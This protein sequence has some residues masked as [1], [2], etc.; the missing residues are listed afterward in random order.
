MI[1][2]AIFDLYTNVIQSIEKQEKSS[3]I[4][5]DFVK[6]FDTEDHRILLKDLDY[7][8]VRGIALRF[9]ESY[10]ANSKQAVKIGLYHSS[11]QAVVCVVPQESVLGPLLFLIYINDIHISSLKVKFHLF[12]DDTCIFNSGKNLHTLENEVSGA[13][14]ISQIGCYQIN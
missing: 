9:F 7:Y 13:L 8:G 12:A 14:K 1:E 11:F 2:H 10:L 3:C 4:F 6:T 5:L